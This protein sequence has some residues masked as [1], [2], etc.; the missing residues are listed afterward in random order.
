MKQ[1]LQCK[2]LKPIDD[3]YKNKTMAD[4]HLNKCKSCFA[5]YKKKYWIENKEALKEYK[6]KH[7]AENQ[8]HYKNYARNYREENIETI[9]EKEKERRIQNSE[10][11][12][13]YNNAYAKSEHGKLIR[14]TIQKRYCL[15]EKGKNLHRDAS[16]IYCDKN[17]IKKRCHS[18]V[19]NAV[20]RGYITAPDYCEKCREK[21]S[22]LHA[23][24]DDYRMPLAVRWLCPLCHKAWHA[25]NGEGLTHTSRNLLNDG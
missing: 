15:T 23:H 2:I 17:P 22:G 11:I 6:K 16:K 21:D 7:R 8:D 25:E 19:R 5:E 4:G 18:I 13:I 3:F 14:E 12:K 24:H 1:C 9:K 20:K 10:Q